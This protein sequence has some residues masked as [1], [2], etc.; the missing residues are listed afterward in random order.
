MLKSCAN[1]SMILPF[2]NSI[3][4]NCSD[5]NLSS[6]QQTVLQSIPSNWILFCNKTKWKKNIKKPCQI[7]D[8][9]EMIESLQQND[10]N[11]YFCSNWLLKNEYWIEILNYLD[12]NNYSYFTDKESNCCNSN[13]VYIEGKKN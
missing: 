9:K 13:Y 5:S 8:L 3:C 2:Y 6:D 12:S 1:C 4:A 7:K 10:S 11:C